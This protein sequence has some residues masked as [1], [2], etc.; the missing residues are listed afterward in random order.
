VVFSYFS[1]KM[2]S[3]SS[4]CAEEKACDSSGSEVDYRNKFSFIAEPESDLQCVIC[5][6]VA[7]DPWQH[8]KCGRLLCRECLKKYGRDKPCPNCRGEQPQYFDD[9]RSKSLSHSVGKWRVGRW[10]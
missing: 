8:N 6:E 3:N 9:N 7:T 2:A 4:S 1:V 10:E 5:L